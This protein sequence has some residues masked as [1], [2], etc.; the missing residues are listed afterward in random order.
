MAEAGV[1]DKKYA[2]RLLFGVIISGNEKEIQQGSNM[3]RVVGQAYTK[4]T[5]FIPTLKYKKEDL[6]VKGLSLTFTGSYN[7][8]ENR[9]VDTSSRVY[10]WTG[11]YTFRRYG[12][13]AKQGEIGEKT[14]YIYKERDLLTMTNL[15]YNI[16]PNHSLTFNHTFSDY[17]RDE[18]DDFNPNRFGLNSPSIKK[19]VMGL[20]YKLTALD[21]K[22]SA[23][24]FGKMFQL[25]TNM[26]IGDTVSISTSQTQTGYGIAGTYYILPV[27]Q[28]KVSYESAYRLPESNELLGDGLTVLSN[29]SLNPEHSYN[30]NA[31]IAFSKKNNIHTLGLEGGFISRSAS[32]F[33]RSRPQGAQSIYEN[34]RS[35]KVTGVEGLVRYGFKDFLLFELN[36]TYQDIVNTDKFDPP[37]SGKISYV[38]KLRIPNIPFFFANA[39]LS[40]RLKKIQS[41]DD[42]L[43]INL[44]G[45]F[46]EAFYLYWPTLGDP[47]YKRDIPRQLTGN[48]GI[49]YSMKNGK[50]NLAID[51]RNVTNLKVYDYFNVQKPGRAFSAKIRYFFN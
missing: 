47:Q 45:N 9:S 29:P 2:D 13:T 39:D 6:I 12:N 33:I 19:Q 26:V 16:S 11:A 24:V 27:L 35:V 30:M 10:D 36:A 48:A 8:S 18:R 14:I 3:Q 23:T 37:G 50:Y 17:H 28:A 46:V 43:T 31:G 42:N 49:T 51:C 20:G 4:N 40:F 5:T 22:F 15:K 1:L 25:A 41:D 21:D 44:G 34:M 38:Y 32:D 7:M